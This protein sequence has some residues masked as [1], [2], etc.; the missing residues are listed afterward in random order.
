LAFRRLRKEGGEFKVSLVYAGTLRTTWAI[1][2]GLR[3]RTSFEAIA[4]F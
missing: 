1:R 2:A 3:Q 4:L